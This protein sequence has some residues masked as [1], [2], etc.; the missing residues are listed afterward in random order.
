[1]CLCVCNKIFYLLLQEI[2]IKLLSNNHECANIHLQ[3]L[4]GALR[5]HRY[6]CK[7]MC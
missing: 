5:V 4:E 1:M 6:S 7:F 2:V 3:H